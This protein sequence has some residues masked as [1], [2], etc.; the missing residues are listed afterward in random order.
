MPEIKLT[1]A[2]TRVRK[3]NHK[4]SPADL[5]RKHSPIKNG[6]KIKEEDKPLEKYSKIAP[7]IY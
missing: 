1:K 3:T 5:L 2:K 4:I 7:K 6:S